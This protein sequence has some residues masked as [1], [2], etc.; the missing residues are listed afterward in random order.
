VAKEPD[1]TANLITVRDWLRYATSQF[2][3]AK[4][5]FGHGT[6]TA[7]DEAAFL[8]LATLDLPIDQLDPWLDARLTPPERDAIADIVQRRIA[9]RRPAPYLVN[10]AWIRG[11][12]FYVDERVI[13]PR[14]YIGELLDGGLESVLDDPSAIS[15]ALDLCTGSGCLAILLATVDAVELSKDA[16][17]VATRNIAGYALADR[18]HLHTGDLFAPVAGRRYDLIISNPPY[19]TQ[20]AVDAF[21]PEYKAEPVM[22]HLGGADGMDLV[23]RILAAAPNHLTPNGTLIVEVGH[24]RAT[25]ERAYPD[26]PFLWL[27][28][29]ASHAEVFALKSTDFAKAPKPTAKRKSRLA[30]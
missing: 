13:V 12:Q 27:D 21:P 17:A 5:V 10:Q 6:S 3:R 20:S 1:Q 23:H 28:T 19:V 2:R 25:L 30:P 22:A 9:T 18:V 14:S 29:E 8:I 11:H 15:T 4:L 26:L 24:G 16:A 7:L